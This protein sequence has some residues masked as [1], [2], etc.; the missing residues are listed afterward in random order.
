MELC[1]H[2]ESLW[3][4]LGLSALGIA[5]VEEGTVARRTADA[6]P[7]YLAAMSLLPQATAAELAAAAEA[8]HGQVFV[9]DSFGGLDL[10]P[11][12]WR[13]GVTQPWMLREPPQPAPVLPAGLRIAP[14][15]TPEEVATFERT[16][17]TAADGNPDWA[18]RGSVHPA[19]TSLDVA[20]LT[21]LLAWLDGRPVGTALAAVDSRVVQVSAVSVLPEARRRGIGAALTQAAATLA[22]EL[23][24][25]LSATRMGHGVYAGLGYRDAGSRALWGRVLP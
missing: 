5:W 22:P 6:V 1:V 11:L 14:V 7:V 9:S 15:G 20:G 2:G 13:L 24:A 18:P 23:P 8:L 17:F 25:V 21:L 12:G 3:H 10:T 16:I 19:A 4:R